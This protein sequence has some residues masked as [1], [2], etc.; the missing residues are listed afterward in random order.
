MPI[1]DRKDRRIEDYALIGD[2]E[3]A[4]L[5]GRDG[6]IDWLCWPRFD[7][8]ACFAALLGDRSNGR[9]RIHPVDAHASSARAYRPDTLI[10]ETRYTTATGEALVIDFMPLR[11]RNSDVMRLVRG[12]SGEV[13]FC[14][15]FVLR[16]DYGSITPWMN[17][18]EDG[19]LRAVGGPDCVVLRTTARLEPHG[20]AH[21]AEFAVRAGEEVAFELAWGPSHLPP[22]PSVEPA[23]ALRETE[24]FWRAWSSR[25]ADAGPYTDVVRRS[26]IT[27]KALTYAPTGGIVAA[28]TTSLPEQPGGERNW[29]YR[30]CWLRDATFTLIALMDAGY[31]DEAAAWRDWLY[32]AVA[33][34]PSQLQIMYGIAGERRLTEWSIPWLS[35]FGGARPVRIG[36]GAATQLQLDVFGEVIDCLYQARVGGLTDD[37]LDWN[38]QRSLVAQ[39]DR[40]WREPDAGLWEVRGPL[41]HFTSSKA[42]VW[43]AYDRAVKSIERFGLKGDV[44]A[45]R[46]TR[47]QVKAEILAKGFD[48]AL[49]SFVQ[50][51]GSKALDASLLLIPLV[52]LL[53][54]TDPRVQGT[55]AAIERRLLRDGFVLRYDTGE[56]D[57]GLHGDEGAFL[58]CSFW[59]ADVYLL[60]GRVDEAR[61]LFERLVR[62]TTNDVGLMSEEYDP[63]SRR[64]LGNFPQALSHIA[65]INTAFNLARHD[66]PAEQRSER[67]AASAPSEPPYETVGTHSD[68]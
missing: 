1:S 19:G 36:N 42:L 24:E 23:R 63:R 43:A 37:K 27:L 49:N 28:P 25:C 17:R 61:E 5:I 9:F 20:P 59:L 38:L 46:A 39:L 13:A 55:V 14:A 68:P 62:D 57:D 12:V 53:P 4:A 54:A 3:T 34:D 22:P 15:E 66:K 45:L 52:G 44:A 50:S 64:F 40:V 18:L 21:T 58:A 60:A 32:R 35:G 7:S 8:G 67:R 2:C 65:L 47:D 41:R 33:G 10:L 30:Y 26:L 16:F 11:D 56:T 29:D 48:P 31:Y 51:Y 6:S